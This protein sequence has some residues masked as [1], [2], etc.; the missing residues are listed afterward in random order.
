MCI[1]ELLFFLNGFIFEV[2]KRWVL[3]CFL[4]KEKEHDFTKGLFVNLNIADSH[5]QDDI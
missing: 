1:E 4:K 2:Q 3:I 5:I